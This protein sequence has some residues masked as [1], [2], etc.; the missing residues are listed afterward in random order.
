MKSLYISLVFTCISFTSLGQK[1]QPLSDLN[2][3][4]EA[5][6]NHLNI[7]LEPEGELYEYVKEHQLSGTYNIDITLFKKGEV[8]SVY[9][10]NREGGSIS[11]QNQFKSALT[12]LRFPVKLPKGQFYKVS[13]TF[14]FSTL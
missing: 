12:D 2:E 9:V 14:N 4:Q 1:K 7:I 13:Y 8:R 3:I 5:A 10:V 6:T 11:M